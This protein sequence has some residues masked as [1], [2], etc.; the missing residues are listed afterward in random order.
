MFL[1]SLNYNHKG[2]TKTWYVVPGNYKEKF[3]QYVRTKFDG[4]LRKKNLLDK[5]VLMIDP[6]ELLKQGIQVYKA[7]QRPR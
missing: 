5:I 7:N 2:A 4:S 6:Q 1:N 3:D